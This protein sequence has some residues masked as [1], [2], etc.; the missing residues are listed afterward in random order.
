MIA[1]FVVSLGGHWS[2]RGSDGFVVSLGGHW[3]ERGS[4]GFVVSLGGHWSERVLICRTSFKSC[5]SVCLSV[6]HLA[7][8]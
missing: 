6:C 8:T 1:G 5:L 4:D 3:R 2:E 7:Q